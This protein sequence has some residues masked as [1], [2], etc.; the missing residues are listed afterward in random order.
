MER[1]V[2]HDVGMGAL[3]EDMDLRLELFE[4][5]RVELAPADTLDCHFR[6]GALHGRLEHDAEA[7]FA[8]LEVLELIARA[9]GA[10]GGR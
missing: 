8:E 2:L 1:A 7:S 4:L 5:A 10:I 3:L 6:S 9:N